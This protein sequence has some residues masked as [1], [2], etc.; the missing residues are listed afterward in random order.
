MA[1][2]RCR[3][4]PPHA[5]TISPKS[6]L[7]LASDILFSRPE[8]PVHVRWALYEKYEFPHMYTSPEL[9]AA[10]P[11]TSRQCAQKNNLILGL[12][13]FGHRS[14]GASSSKRDSP[15]SASATTCITSLT[16]AGAYVSDMENI[17][18]EKGKDLESE[19]RQRCSK[20]RVI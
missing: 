16:Q 4:K 3:S 9:G 20:P 11:E 12:F 17:A 5:S 14:R 2:W 6:L 18:K 13:L 1:S 8:R 7:S 19:G 10:H 15:S